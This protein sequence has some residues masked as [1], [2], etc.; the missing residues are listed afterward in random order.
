MRQE[1][2]SKK[3]NEKKPTG[4]HIP[5][6]YVPV[7][8][9]SPLNSTNWL[10]LDISKSNW[11]VSQENPWKCSATAD[12]KFRDNGT[13]AGTVQVNV[14]LVSFE[15]NI[16]RVYLDHRGTSAP[17]VHGPVTQQNLL[18]IRKA[19]VATGA[20]SMP[21]KISGSTLQFSAADI[22]VKFEG[23]FTCLVTDKKGNTICVDAKDSQGNSIGATF[24]DPSYGTASA[25]AKAI[26]PKTDRQY[27][28]GEVNVNVGGESGYYVVGKSGLSMTNFNYDQITYY[29]P[30]LLPRGY[31]LDESLP[32]YYFP[33]YFSAPWCINVSNQGT[34][35]QRAYGIY[36]DNVAQ[37]YVST[38]D[39]RFGEGVGNKNTL[40]LGSQSSL[41]DYYFIFGKP[42]DLTGDADGS[43]QGPAEVV[44][45]LAYLCQKP[46]A[47]GFA[48]FAAMPPKHIFGYFQ[49]IYGAIA[50]N[51]GAYPSGY[52]EIDNAIFFD[53]VAQGYKGAGMPLEGFAVD[54]DVQDT[55]KV[56]TV[57]SRFF[58]DGDREGKSI[59]QWAHDQGLVTQT[60]VTCFIKDS[61]SNY[62]V[63]DSLVASG[64]YTNNKGADGTE[65]KTD[66]F[67]PA[68]AYC[69]QLQYGE[70][71]KVTAIFPDW[72][73]PGTGAWWGPNYQVLFDKGLDF[74][75]QD[76]TTPSMDSHVIGNDVTDDQF[77]ESQIAKAN[78]GNF[79]DSGAAAYAEKFNWRSY[80]PSLLVTDPRYSETAKRSF[81]EIR[82]Q[83]AYLLCES[84]YDNAVSK[85][86]FSK[87]QRS[88]IIAR[89][90][91]IGSQHFGGLWMGDNSSDWV[92][93]NLM[94]PMIVS[95]SMSGMSVVGADIG[96]FAQSGETKSYVDPELLCRWVEAGCLLPW[97]RNHYDRYISLDPSTSDDPK[98][99]KPKG[100]G[101]AFQELYNEAF[102]NY[103]GPM[104]SA[105]DL[106]YRW[107]EVLYSASF[108]YAS[109]GEPM[110][111]GMCMWYN[112]PNID[113]GK[114]IELNSQFMLGGADGMQILVAP[115]LS[116]SQT[117]R[118]IYFP[119]NANWFRYDFRG[120][121]ANLKYYVGGAR[122]S[123]RL[124]LDLGVFVREGAVLPTRYTLDGSVRSIN[125]YTTKDPLVMD[126]F[127]AIDGGAN[128]I[129]YLDDGG[130]TKDAE[131]QDEFSRLLVETHEVEDTSASYDISYTGPRGYEWKGD[132]F[133]RLRSV[134]DVE[135]VSID[136]ADIPMSD[137]TS[138]ADFFNREFGYLRYW[139]DADSGSVWVRMPASAFQSNYARVKISCRDK[140][141][142]AQP[143]LSR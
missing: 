131:T 90:G 76:M 57:N 73:K 46:A 42:R 91:Q 41:I 68:D 94:I 135:S 32:N 109:T 35:N 43:R 112:D 62:G 71:E 11:L 140:I 53:D 23:D 28:V 75:W 84:T 115:I 34:P 126:I 19:E 138:R 16:F 29:H 63:L 119:A 49:G 10:C 142:A 86:K 39:E 56:F 67:G 47:P 101:K 24:V 133:M 12:V 6:R 132:V 44:L 88:Y 97:F 15:Q 27:G 104:K 70:N 50:V 55:Y 54:I 99:W 74:V 141:N 95:M 26:N 4:V 122:Q 48:K 98:Q 65:F 51:E 59:F 128:G 13:G 79:P 85:S 108:R 18:A 107:Q 105:L 106:R 103:H 2:P 120:D 60:N 114:Y 127:G 33:M 130:L 83:H 80:H 5:Y 136:G 137:A 61:E 143:W 21:F 77:D 66:G 69:G 111:N 36:L 58:V 81:A 96:G 125:S 89:G 3:L 52:P 31:K 117:S 113:Y 139:K 9:F 100:H 45:G 25:I 82:N 102:A 124:D 134:G 7:N 64:L 110:I 129:C 17:K 93:L 40:Y 30:E 72:G 92:H 8:Q 20:P 87:F 121:T 38:G 14:E 116:K 123:L 118:Y 1:M 78:I 37:T 22:T